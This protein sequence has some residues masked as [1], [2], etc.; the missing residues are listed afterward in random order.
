MSSDQLPPGLSIQSEAYGRRGVVSIRRTA[1]FAAYRGRRRLRDA[2][3]PHPPR[4]A[5]QGRPYMH[6]PYF[7]TEGLQDILRLFS[8]S[9]P[10]RSVGRRGEEGRGEEGQ[11]TEGAEW[12]RMGRARKR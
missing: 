9:S 2:A 7:R 5:T 1:D 11:P 12:W 6:P 4:A 3:G 8:P 10:V